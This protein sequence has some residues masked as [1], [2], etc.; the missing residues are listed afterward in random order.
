MSKEPTPKEARLAKAMTQEALAR[1]ARVALATV[2]RAD[3]SGQW[4]KR[5]K[6]L[7][8]YRRALGLDQPAATAPA[9]AGEGAQP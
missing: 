2:S 4:P 6:V 8:R 5:P 9:P 3:R 7:R 1:R